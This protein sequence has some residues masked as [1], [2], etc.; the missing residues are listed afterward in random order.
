MTQ[1]NTAAPH[2]SL[3]S[4]LYQWCGTQS[5]QRTERFIFTSV[6]ICPNPSNLDI[7]YVLFFVY[8]LYLNKSVF[9]KKKN[10]LKG[11]EV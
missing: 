6:C 3:I 1:L 8:Q 2:D 5:K 4:D 11:S 7:K 9:L 10:H